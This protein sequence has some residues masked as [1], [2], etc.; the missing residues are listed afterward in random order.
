MDSETN[1]WNRFASFEYRY[2]IQNL[3]KKK[4]YKQQ[5]VILTGKPDDTSYDNIFNLKV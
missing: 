3:K 1:D 5:L 2:V 4:I